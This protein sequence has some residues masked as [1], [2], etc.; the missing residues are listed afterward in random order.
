[1]CCLAGHIFCQRCRKIFSEM[2]VF[3]IVNA[4]LYLNG[5][6]HGQKDRI[7]SGKIRAEKNVKTNEGAEYCLCLWPGCSGFHGCKN[8]EQQATVLC[9]ED[10]QI[11]GGG[12]SQLGRSFSMN[13]SEVTIS[14]SSPQ[15]GWIFY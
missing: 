15:H 3:C 7:I 13:Y 9:P 2:R 5:T 6:D 14:N 12:I 10:V 1:M 4:N 11:S 8:I